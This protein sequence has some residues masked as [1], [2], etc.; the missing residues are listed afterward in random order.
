MAAQQPHT[1]RLATK[2]R[3][4]HCRL[5]DN[6]IEPGSVPRRVEHLNS[7]DQR[8]PPAFSSA[9]QGLPR[10]ANGCTICKKKA[11]QAT[12]F[13]W[14]TCTAPEHT[15]SKPSLAV[16]PHCLLSTQQLTVATTTHPLCITLGASTSPG[17]PSTAIQKSRGGR[18]AVS[19]PRALPAQ[20]VYSLVSGCYCSHANPL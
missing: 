1:I 15:D 18:G 4:Y 17:S 6:P 5:E 3:V 10:A 12:V 7:K 2:H 9:R 8:A 11:L 16:Q 20:Q 14:K 13:A 19:P